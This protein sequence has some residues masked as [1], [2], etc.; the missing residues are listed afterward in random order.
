MNTAQEYIEG[1][2]KLP[3]EEKQIVIDFMA[4]IQDEAYRVPHYSPED[5]EKIN[6]DIAEAERGENIDG[7]FQGEEA[8]NYLR[9]IRNA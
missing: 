3:P 5:M 6:H 9:R 8:V 1:F 2:K 7:P 4:S